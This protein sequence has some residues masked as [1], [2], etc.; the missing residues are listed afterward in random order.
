MNETTQPQEI[1]TLTIQA[2]R[3]RFG[4]ATSLAGLIVMVFGAKPEWF[5]LDRSPV[6]GFVQIAFFLA[7][8][9]IICLGGYVGLAA[10]WGK[11]EKSILADIG[12]RLISTG[13]V[14]A[15]FSGM[16]DIFG[17]TIAKDAKT[18]FF[19]P[20]QQAGMEV[21]MIVIAVGILMLIPYNHLSKKTFTP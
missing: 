9:T 7:G 14:I 8:L 1:S 17:L 16:A 18:P 3:V 12:S 5:G 15:L 4:L 11:Q 10:L 20:W 13:Y 21:G 2:E 19:G 6:I